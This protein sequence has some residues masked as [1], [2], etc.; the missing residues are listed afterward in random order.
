MNFSSCHIKMCLIVFVSFLI[1]TAKTHETV[2][3][4]SLGAFPIFHVFRSWRKT[5]KWGIVKGY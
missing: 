1:H 5:G 2:R 4:V 3:G